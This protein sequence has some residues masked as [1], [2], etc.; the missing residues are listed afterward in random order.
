[1]VWQDQVAI[2]TGGGRGIGRAIALR[3]AAAGASVAVFDVAADTAAETAEMAGA[4]GG[5]AIAKEVDVGDHGAVAAAVEEVAGEFGRVDVLVN[6]AGVE[7]RSPFLEI[8]PEDWD[9]QIA[10]NLTG[11]FNC[12]QAAA[13]TMSKRGY[14]R[15]VN[16]SSVAGMIGPIDLAAYGASKAGIIGLTR[17]AAGWLPG[18]RRP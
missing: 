7:T 10:V 17:A 1:M 2:V 11:T 16:I 8:T 9:R 13:R 14:G 4:M 18:H 15:I 5:L 3:F 6:N 12:S